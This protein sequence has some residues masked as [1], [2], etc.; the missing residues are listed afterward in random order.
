MPNIIV[1]KKLTIELLIVPAELFGQIFSVYEVKCDQKE[2][3]ETKK[4]LIVRIS[5]LY[6]KLHR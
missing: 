4:S 2:E 3:F 5:P 6:V 1:E